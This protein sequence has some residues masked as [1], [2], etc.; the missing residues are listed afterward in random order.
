[1]A[2]LEAQDLEGTRRRLGD[3]L[4]QKLPADSRELEISALQIPQGAGH[5]NATLLF[6]ARWR[7]RGEARSGGYVARVRPSGRGVFPEYDMQLQFRCMQILGTRSAIPVPKMLW[8]ED[9]EGVLGQP[10][11]LME[12]LDGIVPPDNPPYAI[13]GWVAEAKPEQQDAL[14]R[15]S[16]EL[17]ARIHR[18]DWQDLGFAFLDR[19]EYGPTGL[20]QQL[21]YYRS[22]LDWATGG[23]PT[24]ALVETLAWLEANQP[25]A[26]RVVLNWG[27]ARISNMMYRDFTPVAVLDWEMAC[28]G[29]PEAD[30][31][32]F[33]FMN[34]FLTSAIGLPGI[35]GFPDAAASAAEYERHSGRPV[36]HL[37]YFSVWAAFRFAV[38]MAAIETLMTHNGIDSP[39]I[40]G[41]AVTALDKVR[42]GAS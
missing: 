10:F 2:L 39:G 12:K 14:W 36:R 5:S 41:M 19:P 15:R 27:D 24:S 26:E 25:P 16:L 1:M 11:Y 22:Y 20:A 9:D 23:T 38:I 18:L 30:L 34:D 35:A 32:W 21:A 6:D 37:H 4:Q 13:A 28:L 40:G 3:W 29:P 17:L 42:A 7:E 31:A 8:F 33:L